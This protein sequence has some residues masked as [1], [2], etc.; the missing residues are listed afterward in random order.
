MDIN[1]WREIKNPSTKKNPTQKTG[2]GTALPQEELNEEYDERTE[3]NEPREQ[4]EEVQHIAAEQVHNGVYVEDITNQQNTNTKEEHDNEEEN[5]VE[6]T[7]S[8]T[9]KNKTRKK[10]TTAN[11]TAQAKGTHI[12]TVADT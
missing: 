6:I 10:P 8:S 3:Y 2:L 9:R 7:R 4:A 12:V 11:N 5:Q 1:L